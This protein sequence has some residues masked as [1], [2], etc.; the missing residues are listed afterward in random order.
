MHTPVSAA[1][2]RFQSFGSLLI[3]VAFWV[4]AW[5][6]LSSPSLKLVNTRYKFSVA[7]FAAT[8][9]S[10]AAV[11]NQ[12]AATLTVTPIVNSWIIVQSKMVEAMARKQKNMKV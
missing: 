12:I 6:F 5:A 3:V 1:F 10:S 7:N 4:F 2:F 8:H 9:K 11:A